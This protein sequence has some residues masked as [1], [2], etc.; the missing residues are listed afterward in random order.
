[1]PDKPSHDY[2]KYLFPTVVMSQIAGLISLPIS[3]FIAVFA[4]LLLANLTD[5]AAIFVWP[6]VVF[7]MSAPGLIVLVSIGMWYC[8]R[9]GRGR[10]ALVQ[11]IV[12]VGGFFACLFVFV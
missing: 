5:R 2:P 4:P 9:T 10:A 12:L 6:L 7:M 1:M 8:Y 3:L 11:A